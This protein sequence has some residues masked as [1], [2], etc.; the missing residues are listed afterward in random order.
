M[1]KACIIWIAISCVVSVISVF[2]SQFDASNDHLDVLTANKWYWNVYVTP[3]DRHPVNEPRS[4]E[5]AFAKDG[6]LSVKAD[7]NRAI[8]KYSLA[9]SKISI[10]IGPTTLALC[11][12]AT[13]SEQFLELLATSAELFF[14]RDMLIISLSGESSLAFNAPSIV[15]L[16]GDKVLSPRSKVDS[17]EPAVSS[18]L[19]KKLTEFVTPGP[20]S[21]PGASMLVITPKGRY[22]KSAGV[23]DVSTCAPLKADSQYQIGS[24]TKLMTAAIIYQLQEEGRLSTSD[25]IGKFL[26]DLAVQLQNGD[27]IT[28]E[29]LL[30]HT[31]GLTDYL[32]INNGSGEI[33]AGVQN[34]SILI[35][36]YRPEGLVDM[37]AKSGKSDFKPGESG[38]WKYS[39]TGYILL[40]M[41]IEKVTDRSYEANLTGRIFKPLKLRKTFLQTGTP[42]PN[43]IPQAYYQKP[44]TFS[45]RDWNASQGW[46]AGAV[47]STSPE[48]AVFLKALF[49]GKLFKKRETLRLMLAEAPSGRDVL[50]KGTSYGHGML[51]NNGGLGHGG[52]T[53]GFQSDGG[54]FPEK[55]ITVVIWANS[56]LNNVN[57]TAVPGLVKIAGGEN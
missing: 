18:E 38:K 29:M 8:G 17:L 52:E 14:V 42:A 37:V 51:S 24:N 33:A 43:S 16:C 57:R 10:T 13:R 47:V 11:P 56:A 12:G 30:T 9:G 3:T 41:I 1:K 28:I 40:G 20:L 49:T 27:E 48:F 55:D 35:R 22:F 50:G 36:G 25:R 34:R 2:G 26:P 21:A 15:D 7:C 39:N 53:L 31:S 23:S 44:F 19:D 6:T 45:T 54:Y 46:S 4:Y 5:L 32:G